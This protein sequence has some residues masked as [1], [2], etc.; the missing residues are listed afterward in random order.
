MKFVSPLIL[1]LFCSTYCLSQNDSNTSSVGS[2]EV[3]AIAG[4]NISNV[5]GVD[6]KRNDPNASKNASRGGFHLGA[7]AQL[8][9][10]DKFGFR[11]EF[12]LISTKGTA[13]GN[14]RTTYLDIPLLASFQAG[15]KIKILAGFQPSFLYNAKV[16]DGRGN[17]TRFIRSFDMSFIIGG[18]YQ[19]DNEW[20]VGVR[21]WC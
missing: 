16:G 19:I 2:F 7:Y 11:P 6:V 1:M 18:W 13:D 17:I 4:I 20:G 3:G 14:F 12:H 8:D 10:K 5:V 15:E 21:F 9:I